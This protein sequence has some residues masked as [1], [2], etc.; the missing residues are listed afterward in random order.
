MYISQVVSSFVRLSTVATGAL[1]TAL[2]LSLASQPAL[3]QPF[4]GEA[5]TLRGNIGVGATPILEIGVG[6]ELNRVTLPFPN[7]GV[8]NSDNDADAGIVVGVGN[9]VS[10]NTITTSTSESGSVVI[11]SAVVNGTNVLPNFGNLLPNNLSVVGNVLDAT[12]ILGNLA[13]LNV[14]IGFNNV[15]GSLLTADV[16]GA[17]AQDSPLINA[18]GSSNLVGVTALGN[19]VTANGSI[20]QV[21]P[22]N[23]SL[24]LTAAVN[25]GGV[26]GIANLSG[27]TTAQIGEIIFNE[28]LPTLADPNIITVNALRIRLFPNVEL[29]DA[30]LT[31]TVLG[32]IPVFATVSLPTTNILG[33]TAGTDLIIS[34][35][36]AG[37]LGGNNAVAPEPGTFVLL[38]LGTLVGEVVRRRKTS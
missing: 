22:L 31:G 25:V 19:V 33:V 3:A 26:I 30:T 21:V 6:A 10:L 1:A 2:L 15:N 7:G 13:Q 23:I 12:A 35:T 20:A 11:S 24:S 4:T 28:Q 32:A 14:G 37:A 8:G 29:P 5:Y 27:T 16:I 9:A 18:F 34:S 36:T 38:A 17:N